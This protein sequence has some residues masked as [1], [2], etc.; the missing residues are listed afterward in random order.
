VVNPAFGSEDNVDRLSIVFFHQPN[1]DADVACLPTC[2]DAEHPA[3]Y[4]PVSS[5]DHLRAKFVKQT[6][7]G[8]VDK[9][10]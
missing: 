7:F 10:A 5:G 3:K 1:Y 9:A 4:A 2:Q 8:K 6:T